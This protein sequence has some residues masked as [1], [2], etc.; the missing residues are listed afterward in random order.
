MIPP[1]LILR[2]RSLLASATTMLPDKVYGY[3]ERSVKRG[4]ESGAA[5]AGEAVGA[6]GGGRTGDGGDDSGGVHFADAAAFRDVKIACAVEGKPFGI[7]YR[8][9]VRTGSD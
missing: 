2:M 8:R 4:G 7:D 9:L 1:V 6:W 5:V 3:A